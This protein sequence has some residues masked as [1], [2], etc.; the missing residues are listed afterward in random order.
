MTLLLWVLACARPPAA[1]TALAEA[2]EVPELPG[3]VEGEWVVVAAQLDGAVFDREAWTERQAPGAI[4]GHRSWLFTGGAV[5]SRTQAVFDL[6]D[7]RATCYADAHAAFSVA[8]IDDHR[9]WLVFDHP[10]AAETTVAEEPPI[11]CQAVIEAGDY[12][13]QRLLDPPG[14]WRLIS[15]LGEV[16]DLRE[17]SQPSGS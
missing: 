13:L 14:A 8:A 10:S 11:G 4:G 3:F 1:V 9:W 2:P 7:G 6:P 5:R 17:E 16:E 12:E 15:P